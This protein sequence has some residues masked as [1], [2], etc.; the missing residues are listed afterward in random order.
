L[1]IV[2][3]DIFTLAGVLNERY[4]TNVWKD[5][6]CLQE[7]ITELETLAIIT[8]RLK[9]AYGRFGNLIKYTGPDCVLG[10]WPSQTIAFSVLSNAA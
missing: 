3:T 4:C 8:K 1:G 5:Q 10:S 2:R 9:L 6:Q 7:I